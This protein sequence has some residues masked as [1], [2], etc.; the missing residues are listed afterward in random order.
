MA[1]IEKAKEILSSGVK[2]F[3]QVRGT[4]KRLQNGGENKAYRTQVQFWQQQVSQP[5]LYEF[6][7]L[8]L[9]WVP[10]RRTRRTTR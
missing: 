7:F 10:V 9:R 4:R 6:A 3:L 1:V 2:V 5:W 8:L